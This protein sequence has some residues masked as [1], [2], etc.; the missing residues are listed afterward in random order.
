MSKLVGVR[1][2]TESPKT[3]SKVYYYNTE[4]DYKRGDGIRIKVP[5]GGTPKATIVS[6]NSK[7][8]LSIKVKD[9]EEL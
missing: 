3:K 9:L 2:N 1:I 8:K 6:G 7:K 4:K 5:S